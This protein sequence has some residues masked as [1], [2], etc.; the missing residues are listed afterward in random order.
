MHKFT[1]RRLLILGTLLCSQGAFAAGSYTEGFASTPAGWS[2]AFDTWNVTADY[3]RNI[4]SSPVAGNRVSWYTGRQWTR[5]FAYKVRAYSDW[6]DTGNQLGIVFGLTSST[7]YF[8]VLLNM[9]GAV[10][11]AQV[12]GNPNSP[13][14]IGTGSVNPSAANL[15]VDS[16]FDLEVFVDGTSVIVKVNG[17]NANVASNTIVPVP[18]YIGVVA[19]A[20]LARFDDV[21]VTSQLFRGNF[22]ENDG[23]AINLSAPDYNCTTTPEP[24]AH[25]ACY[26]RFTGTD[27]SGYQ[28][29]PNLWLN[30]ADPTLYGG[31]LH[32]MSRARRADP[33]VEVDVTDYVGAAIETQPGHV[34]GN[35]THVLHQ[36]LVKRQPKDEGGN[37][38][39]VPLAI[40]PRNTFSQQHDLYMRFWLKYPFPFT[41]DPQDYW[42]M[43]WQFVTDGAHVSGDSD[44]LRVSV[45]ATRSA[46]F[47]QVA[48]PDATDG[49][50]HWIVQGDAYGAA[51]NDPPL[52]QKCKGTSEVPTGRWF[53]VEIFL[54][55][56]TSA[57]AP[58]RV[59]VAIDGQEVLDFNSSTD[60]TNAI[61]N[62]YAAGAPISRINLP[63]MYG[64]DVW[65][66]DQYVDDL[67]I[68]DG[69]P[70]NASPDVP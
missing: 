24:E 22:T 11:L 8:E 57:T 43:P 4:N 68:W 37:Q 6:P 55:R 42:Q 45:L 70:P 48:C 17:V 7:N 31:M 67:E 1:F 18:G 65:P 12:A 19:R 14:V 52:W 49:Q 13:T 26:A 23:T 36:W 5:N 25:R 59:W 21:K 9:S 50:W 46:V 35:P 15:A 60:A 56:A 3:Y 28:W 54:H 64:G 30:G 61:G 63:Q 69:F 53:K 66:R 62:M 51:P 58:G 20:N 40:R 29:P 16:W 27:T 41:G 34:N 10:T 38:P 32:H 2:Q 44:V 39:Q 47:N 33:N